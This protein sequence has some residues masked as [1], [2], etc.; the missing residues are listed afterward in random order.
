MKAGFLALVLT[1]AACARASEVSDWWSRWEELI[2]ANTT[3]PAAL[4][5]AL[6]A[7][8]KPQLHYLTLNAYGTQNYVCVETNGTFAW[9]LNEPVAYLTVAHHGKWNR[10]N[11]IHG[12][13]KTI[14]GPPYWTVRTKDA[15]ST[16]YTSRVASAASPDPTKNIAWLATKTV[17]TETKKLY[18]A[19]KSS[20]FHN[21]YLSTKFVLRVNTVGGVSPKGSVCAKSDVDAKTVL[22]ALYKTAYWFYTD[23]DLFSLKE[24]E[25]AIKQLKLA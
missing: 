10:V 14:T 15:S 1:F 3:L 22:K 25:L 23:E 2:K 11:G 6:K 24:F 20:M 17:A 5:D 13:N 9:T 16:V 21:I 18:S 19:A 7:A 12:F 8:P 4:S